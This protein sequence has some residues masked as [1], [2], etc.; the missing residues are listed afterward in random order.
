MTSSIIDDGI[1]GSLNDS[2]WF[3]ETIYFLRQGAEIRSKQKLQNRGS[4]NGD[5]DESKLNLSI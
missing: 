5:F 3:L 1:D 2:C 4:I